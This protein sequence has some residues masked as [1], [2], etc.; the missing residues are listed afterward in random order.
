MKV[1]STIIGAIHIIVFFVLS[2]YSTIIF[3]DQGNLTLTGGGIY[4]AVLMLYLIFCL[5]CGSMAEKKNRSYWGGFLVSFW[6]PVIGMIIVLLL[7][8]PQKVIYIKE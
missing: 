5:A 3:M 1:I 7:P 4:F 2:I 8:Y 6:F